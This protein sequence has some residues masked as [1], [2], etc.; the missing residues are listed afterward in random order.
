M[1]QGPLLHLV[2]TVKRD[3]PAEF[4]GVLLSELLERAGAP[5]GSAALTSAA[6]DL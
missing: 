6:V 1:D 4:E 3:T 2:P 5:T